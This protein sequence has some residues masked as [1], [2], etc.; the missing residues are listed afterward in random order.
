VP[1]VD[2]GAEQVL[3]GDVQRHP[4]PFLLQ[5]VIERGVGKTTE[6]TDLRGQVKDYPPPPPGPDLPRYPLRDM[7]IQRQVEAWLTRMRLERP[8][9]KSQITSIKSQIIPQSQGHD[10]NRGRQRPNTRVAITRI[11]GHWELAT[12]PLTS[13]PSPPP[14]RIRSSPRPASRTLRGRGISPARPPAWAPRRGSGSSR[15]RDR[16][17]RR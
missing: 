11:R 1:E 5:G 13:P 9:G 15:R 17:G 2:T 14:A 6:Y 12:C 8:R 4:S 3:G 10:P 7:E 16:G